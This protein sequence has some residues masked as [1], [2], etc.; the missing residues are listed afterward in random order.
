LLPSFLVWGGSRLLG[1]ELSAPQRIVAAFHRGNGLTPGR[2]RPSVLRQ[3]VGTPGEMLGLRTY[4]EATPAT[5]VA[6]PG[7]SCWRIS[8]YFGPAFVCAL[9]SLPEVLRAAAAHRAGIALFLLTILA[10]MLNSESRFSTFGYP[11]LVARLCLAWRE[12]SLPRGTVPAFLAAAFVLSKSWL[13]LGLLTPA[14]TWNPMRL[15]AFPQQWM[16]ANIGSW[17]GWSGYTLNLGLVALAA[18]LAA[19]VRR[20]RER[21]GTLSAA[22][23]VTAGPASPLPGRDE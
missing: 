8:P 20:T 6:K 13:P 5:S 9:W 2:R 10:M 18:S 3:T 17:M 11:V 7:C 22:G 16:F 19:L 23:G 1:L 21:R 14:A 15:N 4:L 12:T